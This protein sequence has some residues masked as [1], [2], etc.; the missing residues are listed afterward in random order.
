MKSD[1]YGLPMQRLIRSF[2]LCALMLVL[3]PL[4]HC[5]QI[6]RVGGYP[7]SPFVTKANGHYSGITLDVIHALNECQQNYRFEFVPTTAATRYTAFRHG[8]FDMMLFENQ[9][10]GWQ[11]YPVEFIPTDLLDGDVMVALKQSGRDVA[12]F[13]QPQHR[14]L[15]AVE[16]YHYG[17]ANFDSNPDHLRQKFNI[18]LVNNNRNSLLALQRRRGEIALVTFSHLA[19]E[20]AENPSLRNQLLISPHFDNRYQ[21]GV[22][23]RQSGAISLPELRH[24]FDKLTEQQTLTR[25]WEKYVPTDLLPIPADPKS[26]NGDVTTDGQESQAPSGSASQ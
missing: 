23:L 18:L 4:V 24:L 26:I 11:A 16:G 10:W 20:L 13:D 2:L 21:L 5:Q 7:F 9:Q 14:A 8:R 1:T 19:I 17:F 15:I 22:I 3:T 25:L 12:L 6:V